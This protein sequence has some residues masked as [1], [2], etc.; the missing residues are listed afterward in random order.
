MT[1]SITSGL[2]LGGGIIAVA[3]AIKMSEHAHLMSSD[4]AVRAGQCAIGLGLAFYANYIPKTVTSG[5][6]Q[7]TLR[8]TGWLFMLAGVAYALLSAFAPRP[9]ADNASMAAVATAVVLTIGYTVWVCTRSGAT[10]QIM[11]PEA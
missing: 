9:M 1:R 7:T 3:A 5:K 11:P 2:L 8:V 4:T 10:A 6:R